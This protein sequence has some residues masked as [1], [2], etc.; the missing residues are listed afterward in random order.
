MSYLVK[1]PWCSSNVVVPDAWDKSVVLAAVDRNT[2]SCPSGVTFNWHGFVRSLKDSF[3]GNWD[4]SG[5]GAV[6]K[7]PW[8][9]VSDCQVVVDAKTWQPKD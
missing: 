8:G 7:L 2:G 6:S 1:T 4:F 9:N 5:K 3:S